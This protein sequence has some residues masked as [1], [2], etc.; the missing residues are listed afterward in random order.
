MTK[1]LERLAILQF[2]MKSIL[3]LLI[4]FM[5]TTMMN[6]KHDSTELRNELDQV[7]AKISTLEAIDKK[8]YEHLDTL[9]G[10]DLALQSWIDEIQCMLM[11]C[12]NE[13]RN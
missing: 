4:G 7:N 1:R 12:R 8:V 2:I 5:I 9:G 11:D 10:N 13:W 3:L 6:L